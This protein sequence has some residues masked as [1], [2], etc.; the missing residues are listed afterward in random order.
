MK[1]E[2]IENKDKKN[3]DNR[4][5]IFLL[6]YGIIVV[7]LLI[8]IL[9]IAPDKM[10]HKDDEKASELRFYTIEEQKEHLLN[11]QY[12]Y[13]YS[14]LYTDNDGT[15]TYICSGKKN[16]EE[17]N[18]S[19][20]KPENLEY[21]EEN[22]KDILRNLN[23]NYLETETL[24]ELIKDIEPTVS[25]YEGAKVYRYKVMVNNIET[26]IQIF[27]NSIDIFDIQI[28][29]VIEHYHLKYSNILY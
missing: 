8:Y 26:D 29:N 24:F 22:K 18:G 17:E 4:R 11:N 16:K 19:C 2:K 9:F 21:N 14:M 6:I 15:Y 12:S 27:S 28:D 5:W 1:K 13:E 23:M 3:K 20:T 10:F 7:A 25:V